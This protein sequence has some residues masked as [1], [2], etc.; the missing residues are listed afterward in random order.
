MI[1]IEHNFLIPDGSQNCSY[2]IFVTLKIS[3]TLLIFTCYFCIFVSGACIF[4]SNMTY[5]YIEKYIEKLAFTCLSSVVT[6]WV[7]LIELVSVFSSVSTYFSRFIQFSRSVL[8]QF[9]LFCLFSLYVGIGRKKCVFCPWNEKISYSCFSFI[10][11]ANAW[12]LFLKSK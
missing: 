12:C 5:T 1:N 2:S 4:C 7:S 10:F 8:K 11:T 9:Q 6:S 3:S